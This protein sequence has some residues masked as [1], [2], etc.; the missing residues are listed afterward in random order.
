MIIPK[1]PKVFLP[2]RDDAA[3][4]DDSGPD[5]RG[6]VDDKSV[7]AW[8]KGNKAGIYLS[9]KIDPNVKPG[10]DII[11]GFAMKFVYTN[12]VP[13]LEQREIQTSEIFA[14]VYVTLGKHK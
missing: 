4:F 5:L 3:E 8:R 10:D 12:T 14:P 11:T 7:V 6:I 13:A 1:T 2:P 9:A